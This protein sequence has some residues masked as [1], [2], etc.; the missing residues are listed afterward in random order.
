MTDVALEPLIA[1]AQRRAHRRRLLLA[2]AGMAIAAT[3][4]TTLAIRGSERPRP[5]AV[6]PP[7]CR[8]AQLKVVLSH[9]GVAAG[10]LGDEFTFENASSAGCTLSGWPVLRLVMP[11]GGRIF[12]TQPR[13]LIAL[14]YSVKH[15]PPLPRIRLGPGTTTRWFLMAADGTGLHG[16][17]QWSR[18]L[19]VVPPGATEP[20]RVSARVPFCGR[21]RFWS[22]PIGRKP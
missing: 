7:A 20:V 10:T 9:G 16:I 17:C 15:P 4:G 6:A 22:L 5:V 1:E 18:R 3:A 8:A 19:L 21:R 13:D 12:T 11:G 2:A 14:A